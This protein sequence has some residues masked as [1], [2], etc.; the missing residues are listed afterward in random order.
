VY[1]F[2]VVGTFSGAPLAV[3]SGITDLALRDQGGV[4]TL[5]AAGRAGGGLLSLNVTTGIS[6]NDYVTVP[7]NGVLSA[8]SRLGVITVNG[9]PS[10]ILTGP[11]GTL[12]AVWVRQP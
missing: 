4:V 11:S 12:M 2:T 7:V 1:S 8:P 9:Y 10:V 3:V 5:Y 6:L